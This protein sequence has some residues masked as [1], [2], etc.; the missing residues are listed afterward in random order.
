MH[1]ADVLA[2]ELIKISKKHV[3]ATGITPSGPIHIGNMREVL[4]T[5]AVYRA[6]IKRD[7][8]V[9][10][11]YI[12]DD[13]DHLRKRYP[14]LPQTFD[15]CIGKP[16]SDIPCPC[17]KHDSYADHYLSDFLQ[18]LDDI[19]IHPTIYRAKDMYKKGMYEEYIQTALEHTQM[20]RE[21]IE[22]ISKRTL[23]KKWIPFNV[24]CEQCGRMTT[25]EPILY[26]FPII[27]YAC[28]CGYAGT[29]DIR[30]GGVG[31]LPWRI[32]WPA[33]WKMLQVTFEP[34]GKDH[35]TMGGARQT[36][37]K[38][39]EDVYKYPAPR[40]VVYEFILLKG[41]GAMHS[42]T[43]TGLSASEML[44]MTPPEVLRFLIMD[45]QPNKHIAFDPGLGLLSL[46]D[47]YDQFERVYFGKDEKIKGMKDLDVTYELS[48][49]YEIPT[50][51][52]Q[53]V[54][55]R[56][57]VTLVQIAESWNDLIE[58]LHRTGQIPELLHKDDEKRL[59]KRRGHV[60][61]WLEHF[62]PSAVKFDV[63]KELPICDLTKDQKMVLKAFLEKVDAIVWDAESIHN[64]MYAIAE[65]QNV[66]ATTVFTCIY[67][68]ILGQ[69][70][71]PRIGF[72]LS[73]LD[74]SFVLRRFQE[75]IT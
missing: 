8:D 5:D 28:S 14:Y 42:S 25:T 65:D 44:Q 46:V 13:Y 64:F 24:Q 52:P 62:A 29:V 51:L 11:I 9:E 40:Y 70:N 1:W 7:A 12:A 34:F 73:N 56:H 57:L 21:I 66:P 22:T 49:P 15:E 17:G 26:E 67:Q 43:G 32:D 36:G 54:P 4:T 31:K 59:Q 39:V 18:S 61:Y 33:R 45:H 6:L 68:I 23:P 69:K 41:K 47:E 53:Q 37:E 19:G 50:Q 58:I 20:I 72:F 74:K 2:E 71:G 35:A 3:L 27:E 16:I 55:Y 10:Y 60:L 38:I 63:K 48:Q 75:A 30:K